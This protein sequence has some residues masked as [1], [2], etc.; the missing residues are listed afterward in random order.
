[1]SHED[2]KQPDE[3][4]RDR[5]R[6]AAMPSRGTTETK[7]STKKTTTKKTVATPK[8]APKR[9]TTATPK[10]QYAIPVSARQEFSMDFPS[11]VFLLCVLLIGIVFGTAFTSA[12][13]RYYHNSD[14]VRPVPETLADFVARESQVLSADERRK[15]VAITEQILNCNF[16]TPSALREEFYYQ[17]VKAGLLDSPG[18]IAFWDKWAAK[19]QETADGRSQTADS[20]E[21]MREVYQQLLRG[22]QESAAVSKLPSAVFH[23]GEPVEGLL[24]CF[25][26]SIINNASSTSADE[27]VTPDIEPDHPPLV[28]DLSPGRRQR[29]LRRIATNER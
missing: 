12:I 24:K 15:L 3:L 11:I 26:P 13:N 25:S 17:R 5:Q 10:K 6:F 1:M 28:K 2:W 7:M 21:F 19:V 14:V 22:L 20:I 8:A 23:S 16:D 29:V 4:E 27:P 18:F 9:K